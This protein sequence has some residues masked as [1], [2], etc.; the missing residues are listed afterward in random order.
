VRDSSGRSWSVL[1]TLLEGPVDHLERP[2]REGLDFPVVMT[3]GE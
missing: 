2:A 3:D 1:S